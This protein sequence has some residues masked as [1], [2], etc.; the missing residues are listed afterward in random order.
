MKQTLVILLST[1]CLAAPVVARADKAAE[2]QAGSFDCAKEPAP[3]LNGSGGTAKFVGTCDKIVI[4]GSAY[5]VAIESAKHV[6]VNG[7]SNTVEIGSADKISV[8]GSGNTV[9]YKQ[10]LSGA[11]AKVSSVGAGNKVS[12]VK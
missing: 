9:S 4:N 5:T 8:V 3:V 7:S 12:K 10:G 1:L 6:A 11:K 2:P